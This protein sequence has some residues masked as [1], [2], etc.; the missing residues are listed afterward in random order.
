MGARAVTTPQLDLLVRRARRR[1]R[2]NRALAVAARAL[3]VAAVVALVWVLIGRVVLLPDIE[4]VGG[5]GLVTAVLLATAIAA[6]VRIRPVWAAWAADRWLQTKDRFSTAVEVVAHG[7]PPGT[8]AADQIASAELSAAGIRRFP[9]GPNI[10]A[11]LIG[12]GIGI[13]ALAVFVAA[14]PNP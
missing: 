11:R 14:L 3:I 8:L 6:A 9:T 7:T 5:L 1:M 4:V 12:I 13:A 2:V 10:P